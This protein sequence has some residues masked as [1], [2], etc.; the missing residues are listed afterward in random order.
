MN[1][2]TEHEIQILNQLHQSC[3]ITSSSYTGPIPRSFSEQIRSDIEEID[4]LNLN[5]NISDWGKR[6]RTEREKM[7]FTL[8]EIAARLG[9]SHR[10]I[11]KQEQNNTATTV[12]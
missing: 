1:R 5:Q 9:V 7:N 6:C 8:L 2:G 10:A 3:I 11:Q 4:R 12:D